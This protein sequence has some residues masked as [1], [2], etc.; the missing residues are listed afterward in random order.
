MT[1]LIASLALCDS[2]LLLFIHYR[3]QVERRH[4]EIAKLRTE[5]LS[6]ISGLHQRMTSAQ[7]HM[8]TARLELRHMPDC[9]EKY[10][11]VEHF[12]QMIEDG[13]NNLEH[14]VNIRNRLDQLG[15]AKANRSNVLMALQSLEHDFNKLE[16]VTG[17]LEQHMLKML[18]D[19]RSTQEAIDKQTEDS[20]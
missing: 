14:L 17:A 19:I 5:F 1:E 15:T 7:L 4:G 12:P 9:D 6:R 2:V 13:K 8:E 16:E 10:E 20:Q 18:T 3:N 11:S